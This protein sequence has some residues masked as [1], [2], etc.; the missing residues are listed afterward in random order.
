MQAGNTD[1]YDV[2]MLL[3]RHGFLCFD[4]SGN[5]VLKPSRP[6]DFRGFVDSFEQ[7]N[8]GKDP[9]GYWDELMCINT[10]E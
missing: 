8:N 7:Y 9:Y 5:H 1:G 10:N 3:H 6:S 2:L 4:W